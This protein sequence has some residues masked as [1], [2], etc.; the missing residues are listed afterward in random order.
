MTS[1]WHALRELG[2][3]E[4]DDPGRVCLDLF[5]GMTVNSLGHCY[6][7]IVDELVKR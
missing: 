6:P 1:E 4:L 2:T 5:A 3:P 7:T